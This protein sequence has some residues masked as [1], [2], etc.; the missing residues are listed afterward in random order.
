MAG[1]VVCRAEELPPGSR[2]AF[3]LGGREITVFNVDG[4]LYALRNRC[5][6]Q[7]GRLCDGPLLGLLESSRPGEYRYSRDRMLIQ[8]PWH[9]WEFDIAT[10]QSYFDPART[11]VRAYPVNVESGAALV[12]GPYQAETFPVTVEEDYVVVQLSGRS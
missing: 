9:G 1:H 7:G 6:H 8:C 4:E 2:R 10:G 12:P 11:R 3:K 5:P